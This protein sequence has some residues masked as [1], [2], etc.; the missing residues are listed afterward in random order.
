M[1]NKIISA[2]IIAL[3]FVACKKEEEA[4]NCEPKSDVQ[5]STQ[6][7]PI[8]QAN[9]NFSVCHSSSGQANG[10][11]LSSYASLQATSS[12]EQVLGA[13]QHDPGFDPMPK[14]SSK[15]PDCQIQTIATWIDEGAKDN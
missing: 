14:N 2:I 6:V 13:I 10:I 3:A 7:L 8:F 4:S 5:F 12:P 1:K 9:C 15:L 11:D